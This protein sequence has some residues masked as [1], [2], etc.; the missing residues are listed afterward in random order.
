[1]D[2][3]PDQMYFSFDVGP[4]HFISISTEY[5][6]YINYGIKMVAKQYKWIIEDLK[7]N[8]NY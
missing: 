8:S 1:M 4:I 6:Y 3:N 2:G 7:V 5:Y